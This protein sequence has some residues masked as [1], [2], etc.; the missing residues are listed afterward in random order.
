VTQKL[1][2]PT[3]LQQTLDAHQ[4]RCLLLIRSPHRLDTSALPRPPLL[5]TLLVQ[6]RRGLSSSSIDVGTTLAAMADEA[7]ATQG[8]YVEFQG[9]HCPWDPDK[10]WSVD[11][12]VVTELR[13]LAHLHECICRSSPIPTPSVSM[14]FV[15]HFRRPKPRSARRPETAGDEGRGGVSLISTIVALVYYRCLITRGNPASMS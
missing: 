6:L 11:A 13:H 10:M 1:P 15:R 12:A 4:C 2:S 3:L 9:V 5:I 7:T 8:T 14:A